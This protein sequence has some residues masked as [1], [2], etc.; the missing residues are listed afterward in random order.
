MSLPALAFLIAVTVGPNGAVL[1]PALAPVGTEEGAPTGALAETVASLWVVSHD[2]DQW[3]WAFFLGAEEDVD[4]LRLQLGDR[5]GVAAR[6]MPA[7]RIPRLF[8]EKASYQADGRYRP[9]VTLAVDVG[10][11]LFSA[12]LEAHVARR[13]AEDSVLAS[14]MNARA[15]V[16]MASE[17]DEDREPAYRSAL[18]AFGATALS[19]AN[20]LGRSQRRRRAKRDSLCRLL[21]QPRS[22]MT[23]WR[24]SVILGG[25]YPGVYERRSNGASVE[26]I[27]SKAVLMAED[28]QWFARA[29]LDVEWT[30]DPRHDFPWLCPP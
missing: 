25:V 23:H 28:K 9:V 27:K 13:M 16:L 30:G 26:S 12:V 18:V 29:F 6:L 7:L 22:L 24:D 11:Y 10:E 15:G 21:D 4:L 3:N 1:L 2:R 14:H 8:L 5:A 17:P 20:E 19:V